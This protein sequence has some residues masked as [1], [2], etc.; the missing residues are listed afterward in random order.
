[1]AEVIN[2]KQP[3]KNNNARSLDSIYYYLVEVG[4]QEAVEAHL[5]E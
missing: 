2:K 5:C 3:M 1:M 4:G